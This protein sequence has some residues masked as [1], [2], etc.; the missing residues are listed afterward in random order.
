MAKYNRA[1]R[2]VDTTTK[3]EDLLKRY[4]NMLNSVAEMF[5]EDGPIYSTWIYI[6][7]WIKR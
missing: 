2:S 6:S 3:Q 7:N 4:E 5:D 1:P